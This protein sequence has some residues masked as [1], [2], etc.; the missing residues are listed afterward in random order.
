MCQ[1]FVKS[2]KNKKSFGITLQYRYR[3]TTYIILI[4]Q[5]KALQDSISQQMVS[6]LMVKMGPFC[7][8]R[9]VMEST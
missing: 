3:D 7:S 5:L 6:S 2:T 9:G 1:N 4:P 8:R